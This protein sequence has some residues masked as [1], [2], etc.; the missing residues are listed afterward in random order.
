MR[1]VA[2][3]MGDVHGPLHG[4]PGSTQVFHFTRFL[5]AQRR[6]AA[7]ARGLYYVSLG[8]LGRCGLDGRP[9]LPSH[10]KSHRVSPPTILLVFY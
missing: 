2:I 1:H 3:N 4:V 8:P 6:Y 7:A 9:P 5:L 10:Y